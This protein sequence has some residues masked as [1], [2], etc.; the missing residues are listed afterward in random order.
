MRTALKPLAHVGHTAVEMV[1]MVNSIILELGEK[2]LCKEVIISGGIVDFLD[3]YYLINK[4]NLN[5][6]YGQ[7]S[8]FLKYALEDYQSLHDYVSY[9]AKGLALAKAYLTLKEKR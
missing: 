3:G 7:A 9:Q 2:M 8:S 5:S 6:V 1:E 4:L